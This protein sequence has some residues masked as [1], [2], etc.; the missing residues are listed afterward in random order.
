[1]NQPILALL[2]LTVTASQVLADEAK[3]NRENKHGD[4]K[5]S[6][7]DV[8]AADASATEV[9][10]G[11]K[12]E[13]FM[14]GLSYPTSI[15][16]DDSGTTY[17]AEAG[18]SYGDPSAK[19]RI[20]RV[21]KAGEITTAAETGLVGPI[22]DL[23]WHEGGLYISHRGKISVLRDG[24]V[25]DL[26]TGLP[27]DGDHQNNQMSV[28]PDGRVYF[29][30]GTATNSGVVG[31][32]NFKMGWLKKHPDFHDVPAHAL[33]LKNTV[34][35]TKNPREEGSD[36]V[37]TSAFHPFGKAVREETKVAGESKASGAILS[38]KADGSDLQVYAWGLRNPYGVCWSPDGTL[39]ATENGF[40]VRGSRPI[41]ND[42]EDIYVIKK[43]AWYGWP[44]F[45]SGKPVTDPEFKPKDEPAPEFLMTEHP[46]V[47]EPLMT[48]PKHSAITKIDFSRGEKFGFNGQ[49]F[50]AFFGHM[51]PMTGTVEE[52]GG[53][54]VARIDLAT[55]K[56]ETFFSKK[57][58]GKSGGHH[59]KA[60]GGKD[61]GAAKAGGG[62]N[63]HGGKGESVSAGPRRLVGVRFSPN[64]EALYVV[65][66]G[67]M[68]IDE[69][70]QPV[71]R[72]GVVWRITRD[73]SAVTQPPGGLSAPE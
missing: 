63:S 2:A 40:D 71:R 42:K 52:H 1:M 22:N 69:K 62:G 56:A 39:Y 60:E 32:D 27:S 8:P 13:V 44:D 20:L 41:A 19:P 15:E 25:N 9:P 26:V 4:S 54:R 48:F 46:K 50:V 38:M 45:A 18:Y 49:M 43:G 53:H 58:H 28:G 59:A 6:K 12:V 3:S 47:E 70:P 66:Y 68:V 34:F 10:Q 24:K 65:D 35:T 36:A 37:A 51:A 55:K 31:V 29:G 11:Y 72:T 7:A 21:S 30:Q 5:L 67:T 14:K 61:D 64:G 57:H 23:L 17:V 16:F 73:G 33:T